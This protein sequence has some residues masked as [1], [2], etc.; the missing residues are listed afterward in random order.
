MA[1]PFLYPIV[2]KNSIAQSRGECNNREVVKK[3]PR[4][5]SKNYRQGIDKTERMGYNMIDGEATNDGCFLC[6]SYAK[7]TAGVETGRLSFFTIIMMIIITMQVRQ[8]GNHKS[9]DLQRNVYEILPCH[10]VH[11]IT[12][13]HAS[14]REGKSSASLWDAQRK[15]TATVTEASDL[16]GFC[17][18]RGVP[19]VV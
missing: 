8:N 9:N 1:I 15:P 10:V 12:S 2:C 5:R 18:L 13:P 19:F 4:G 17:P 6:A 16:Y 11:C 14:I 3:K 7:I